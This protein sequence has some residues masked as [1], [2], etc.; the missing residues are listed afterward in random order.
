MHATCDTGESRSMH[1]THTIMGVPVIQ[2]LVFA[3][4]SDAPIE[5]LVALFLM[6]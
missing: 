5:A 1:V 6:H 4:R 2:N 3:C